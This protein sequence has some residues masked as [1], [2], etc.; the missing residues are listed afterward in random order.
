M[1]QN[2]IFAFSIGCLVSYYVNDRG[3]MKTKYKTISSLMIDDVEGRIEEEANKDAKAKR[4]K[5]GV[6]GYN[7]NDFVTNADTSSETNTFKS[8]TVKTYP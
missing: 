3:N 4:S 1:F 7:M 5:L 6:A 8:F 2:I